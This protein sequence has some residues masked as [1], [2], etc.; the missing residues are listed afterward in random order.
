MKLHV[1]NG[2]QYR[3]ETKKPT[4]SEAERD[5]ATN[6]LSPGPQEREARDQDE[7]LCCS[8]LPEGSPCGED[9]CGRARLH[10]PRMERGGEGEVQGGLA[11]K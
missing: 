8:L 4:A 7:S 1:S 3:L 6:N 10:Q 9:P 11:G 5:R 2:L